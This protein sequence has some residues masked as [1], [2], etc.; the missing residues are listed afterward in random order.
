V[1]QVYGCRCAFSI[2][3]LYRLVSG[4]PL[5]L[6]T[7]RLAIVVLSSSSLLLTSSD[8]LL[9]LRNCFFSLI[10]ILSYWAILSSSHS[11][12]S[13]VACLARLHN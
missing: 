6:M 11:T 12:A 1:R 7:G 9:F 4:L 10:N 8:D 3:D 13:C 5:C 2:A